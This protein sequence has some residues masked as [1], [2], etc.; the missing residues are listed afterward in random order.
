MTFFFKRDDV[1]YIDRNSKMKRRRRQ[2]GQICLLV[3]GLLLI[4]AGVFIFVFFEAIYEFILAEALKFTPDSRPY[5]AWRNNDPPLSMDIFLFNWTNPEQIYNI[6]DKPEFQEVGPYRFKEIKEKINISWHEDNYTVSY[7][8]RKLYYFDHENSLR[9]LT[10]VISTINPVPLT[11]GFKTRWSSW[12][13]KR[14][15][16]AALSSVSS[17]H[18]TKNVSQ[19]LFEGYDE[20]ILGTLSKFPW[21][22]VQDKFGIFYGKNNTFGKDGVFSMHYKNDENFGRL[23]TWNNKNQTNFYEGHCN[24]IKGSA[25][26]FYPFHRQRQKVILYSAEL[27]KYAEL[28]YVEDVV[29]KGVLGYKYTADNIFDNGTHR[30]E[31]A[32]FCTG[33]CIPSGVFN[34]ST[35]RDNS[36]S[37]LSFPHFYRAD[38]Y[39][40][41]MMRGMRPD[42]G[43]HEFYIVIEP[44]SGVIMNVQIVMQVNML[45]Q[46][47]PSI[48]IYEKVPKL[49]IPL[50]Y[51]TQNIPLADDVASSLR[52]IQNL[53]EYSNYI[54]YILLGLGSMSIL[55]AL[56]SCIWC[57]TSKQTFHVN[58]KS[59]KTHDEIPLRDKK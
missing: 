49:Y 52:L 37:F 24:D 22:D 19:I 27:C 3:L 42:K 10:D 33:E 57:Y 40:T 29:I 56:C 38:P 8:H 1:V 39:Y 6:S 32:C 23:V 43:K 25:G 20:P 41:D 2:I 21:L 4:G 9:K 14:V 11:I 16:S 47:I 44:I 15:V 51:F 55:W 54:F 31:N 17:L 50:F 12:F 59:K 53:P 28:E 13:T 36:P 45:L 46:P 48:R 26:E 34:V 35:C 7:Q 58:G 30:P 5:K 18:V